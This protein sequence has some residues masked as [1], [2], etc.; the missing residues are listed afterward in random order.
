M[1]RA[2]ADGAD[3]GSRSPSARERGGVV[4]LLLLAAPPSGGE[5]TGGR[6]GAGGGCAAMEADGAGLGRRGEVGRGGGARAVG[7]VVVRT[8]EAEGEACG[9]CAA[10]RAAGE[11]RP[12]V[13]AAMATEG[14]EEGGVSRR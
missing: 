12:E 1:A 8:K 9:S 5:T 4:E 2:S 6:L 7:G 11:E 10:A 3:G 13:E 14:A